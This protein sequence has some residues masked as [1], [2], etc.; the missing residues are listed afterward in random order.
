[1]GRDGELERIVA[2]LAAG[3]GGAVIAG[4]PGTGKTRLATEVAERAAAGGRTVEW[5]RATRS[6]ASIPFG[7]FA[8]LLPGGEDLAA[9][10]RRLAGRRLVL[11]VD[12]AQRL[13]PGSAALVHQLAA[14]GEATVLATVRADEPAPDAVRALWKDDLCALV[15]LGPL[16]RADADRLVEAAL[17]GP[18]DGRARAGLWERTRGNPL[19][20]RELLR[21]GAGLRRTDGLWHWDGRVRPGL[22]LADLVAERAAGLAR[23]A[24]RTLELIAAGAPI[25]ARLLAPEERNALET[26]EAQELVVLRRDGRREALDLAHPLHGDV[27]RARLPRARHT[28]LLTR[29]ADGVERCGARRATDPLRVAGWRVEAGGAVDPELLTRAAGDALAAL[30]GPLSARLARAAVQAGGGPA[31]RLALGR[32]LASTGAAAEAEAVLAAEPGREAAMARARNLFW[33]LDCRE[34]ADALLAAS[35]DAELT[36]LR[37]RLASAAGR[38]PAA[39]AVALPLL[40]DVHAPEPARVHAALAAGE[41]LIACGRAEQAAALVAGWATVAAAH[42]AAMPWAEPVL[43]SMAGY[44]LRS[45]GRPADAVA[46]H[47]AVYERALG[48]GSG[49]GTAVESGMLG[50][51]WLARGAVRTAQRFFRESA[52]LLRDADAVGMRP[53]ALAGLAQARAQAGDAAAAAAALAEMEEAPLA[54]QGFELELRL[55]RAWTAAAAGELSR[56]RALAAEGAATARARG[57]DGVAVRALHELCRIGGAVSAGSGAPEPPGGAAAALE[58]LARTVEGPF[59]PLAAAHARALAGGD[60]AALLDAA[61]RFADCGASLLAAEAA[62]AAAAALRETGR[63]ASARRAEARAAAWLRACEGARPPALRALGPAEA[64]TPREREVAL[65]AAGGLSSSAIAERL[66]VSVRTVDNHLQRVYGKLG[67]GG[68]GELPAALE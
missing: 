53:W 52:T 2:L 26:L 65:L 15:E 66:V 21:D 46:T 58:R 16:A 36:A 9:A 60:G 48:R 64:L 24:A 50:Y 45:A 13:D 47:E 32:A 31:A 19:F 63:A 49:E 17:G 44:A 30:D 7:A 3:E 20:L 10:R 25:E 61:G 38:S 59:A 4:A 40:D 11:C 12:D 51:A 37:A 29:L 23:P 33:G 5:V 62:A 56:G 43:R 42:T 1:V 57:Q 34:E 18:V 27:V 67:I 6:A 28:A 35:D 55:A 54:H 41:A 8:P 39:L 22:R 14:A 68:R